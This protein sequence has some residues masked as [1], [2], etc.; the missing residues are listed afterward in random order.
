MKPNAHSSLLQWLQDNQRTIQ[1]SSPRNTW[2]Y[3]VVAIPHT[4]WI[5]FGKSYEDACYDLLQQ[6]SSS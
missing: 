4:I 5:A 1:V 6:V 2:P 3:W